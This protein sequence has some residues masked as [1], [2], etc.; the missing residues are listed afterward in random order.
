VNTYPKVGE[1]ITP[2]FSCNLWDENLDEMVDEVYR[3]ELLLVLATEIKKR[4]K[5]INPDFYRMVLS[6][7]GKVGWI[8]LDNCDGL[9]ER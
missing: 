8:H 2:S 3:G 7:H 6:S 9:N 5:R 4:P 1:M